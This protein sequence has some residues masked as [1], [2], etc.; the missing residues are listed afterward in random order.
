MFVVL[1]ELENANE[2]DRIEMIEYIK[3]GF[4]YA[5]ENNFD[6]I[7]LPGHEIIYKLFSMETAANMHFDAIQMFLD[8]RV[9]NNIKIICVCI[10]NE[11]DFKFFAKSAYEK[12]QKY[13]S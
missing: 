6:G 10:E 11:E 3:K 7:V 13:S 2:D 8:S 9:T 12:F 5:E 4:D 1:D